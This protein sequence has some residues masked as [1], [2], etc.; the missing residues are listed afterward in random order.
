MSDRLEHRD[1][2]PAT[3]QPSLMSAAATNW[4]RVLVGQ[5]D[6]VELRA[7]GGPESLQDS[8]MGII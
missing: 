5:D 3:S 8:S 2:N 4:L 7:L 6:I 1:G